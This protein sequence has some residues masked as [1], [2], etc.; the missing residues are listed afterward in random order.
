MNE[1]LNQ[2][3]TKLIEASLA[4]MDSAAT[5]LQ[6]EIPEVIHQLLL[7][8]LTYH[9]IMFVTG[10]AIIASLIYVW[11]KYSGRGRVLEEGS[12]YRDSKYSFTLTHDERGDIGAHMIGS[13]FITSVISG[14]VIDTF[15]NLEWLQILIAPKVWL[16][17]YA[18][19]LVK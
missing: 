18:A 19:Q 14:V 9:L 3:L 7:W 17:E 4:A 5:F 10:L 6:A 11:G 8:H 1:N 2:A 12:N 15:F 13:V 16:I